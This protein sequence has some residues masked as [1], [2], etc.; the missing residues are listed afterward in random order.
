MRKASN[1]VSNIKL[2]ICGCGR[3]QHC[4]VFQRLHVF[5]N[6]CKG[7]ISSRDQSPSLAGEACINMWISCWFLLATPQ[8]LRTDSAASQKKDDVVLL[9]PSDRS[10]IHPQHAHKVIHL[11]GRASHAPVTEQKCHY[12]EVG[13][14]FWVGGFFLW[15]RFSLVIEGRR[16][17]C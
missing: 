14:F 16:G 5:V 10:K 3:T 12:V 4:S 11:T 15:I 7:H 1:D 9:N 17:N 13:F 8:S 2:H 6:V